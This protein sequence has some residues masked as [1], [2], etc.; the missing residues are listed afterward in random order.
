MIAYRAK[1]ADFAAWLD[2]N[3]GK[4]GYLIGTR[5]QLCTAALI[6]AKRSDYSSYVINI[7]KYAAQWI[8]K[9]VCDCMGVYECFLNGGAYD[10]PLTN[11][12]YSDVSTGSVYALVVNNGIKNG[13]ISTLPK[14]CPY[15]IA[16]GY[17]GHV[18]FYYRG[19][20]YQCSG[21]A[22]GLEITDLASTAHNHTWQYWYYLPWL[23]Y[24]ITKTEGVEDE[25]KKGDSGALVGSWQ[26]ALLLAGY[27][28]PKFGADEDFGKETETATKEFQ[29]AQGLPP[30]GV[31][32]ESTFMAMIK[33]MTAKAVS[34]AAYKSQLDTAKIKLAT[35]TTDLAAAKSSVTKLAG[36]ISAAKAA[37]T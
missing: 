30:S 2:R 18:G 17:S 23:D 34:A 1:G 32:G 28:L 19:K 16:V 13:P 4:I 26:N 12:E 24:T 22:Y 37:L 25:M 20:V 3:V 10:K 29:T 9:V 35:A 14:N 15:P 7:D 36:K 6:A 5:G 27:K 8:G 11:M 21:H 33:V 31:V